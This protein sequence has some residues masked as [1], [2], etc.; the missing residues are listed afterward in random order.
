MHH[1]GLSFRAWGCT[2]LMNE[3]IIGGASLW[4]KQIILNRQI[5]N[6]HAAF[7]RIL[8]TENLLT[9]QD[10]Y[11]MFRPAKNHPKRTTQTNLHLDMNPWGY[12]DGK[13]KFS[14][15]IL[16]INFHCFR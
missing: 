6:I 3:G 15:I 14:S 4:T 11:G 5:P 7:A 16:I 12:I 10:R 13:T 9:N 2:G 1:V 8:Q